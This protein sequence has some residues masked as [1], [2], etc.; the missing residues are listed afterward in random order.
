MRFALLAR[1][2]I[3]SFSRRFIFYSLQSVVKWHVVFVY[4]FVYTKTKQNNYQLS[5]R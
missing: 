2:L 4:V 1:C 5:R 3:S